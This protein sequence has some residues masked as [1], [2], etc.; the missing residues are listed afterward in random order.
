MTTKSRSGT[1]RCGVVSSLCSA[2][3]T[4][5]GQCSS[6]KSTPGLCRPLT[7]RQSG[8]KHLPLMVGRISQGLRPLASRAQALLRHLYYECHADIEGPFTTTY[9]FIQVTDAFSQTCILLVLSLFCRIWNW[10]SRQCVSV[11][12]GHNHY[13]MC[14]AFHIKED[15]VVS[16]S[17]DQTVRVSIPEKYAQSR[18]NHE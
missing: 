15:L 10:M 14:A 17:L 18:T 2:I 6:T 12:T 5:F 4:T 13:V 16:A 11:L 3:S 9:F 7:T 8:D 1:T